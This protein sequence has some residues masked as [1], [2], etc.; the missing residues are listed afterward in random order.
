M[1]AWNLETMVDPRRRHRQ[2][3][4]FLIVLLLLNFPVLAIVDSLTLPGGVPATPSYL[5]A[6]WVG[7]IALAALTAR[8]RRG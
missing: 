5:L 1:S 8:G 7:A 4:L 3:A 6:V 2:L